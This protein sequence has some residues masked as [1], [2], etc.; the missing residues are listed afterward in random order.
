MRKGSFFLSLIQFILLSVLFIFMFMFYSIYL[1]VEEDVD[2]MQM[3]IERLEENIFTNNRYLPKSSVNEKEEIITDEFK[4]PR[5][6]INDAYPNLLAVDHFYKE[7]LPALL[8]SNFKPHGTLK[9]AVIGPPKNLHPFSN[10]ADVSDW[11]SSC[12]ASVSILEFGKFET[13]AE[14]MAIKMEARPQKNANVPEFWIHL[15]EGMFWQ[16]LTASLF[17]EKVK[18]SP[19]F[20]TRHP[21]TAQDF[22]FN[23]D[24]IMNP[25]VEES[26]AVALRTYF[27]GIEEIEIIDELTFIVRWKPH[28]IKEEKGITTYKIPYGA[29]LLTGNLRPLASFLY[30]YFSDGTKIVQDD[31]DPETYRKSSLWAQNFSQHWARNVIPSCGPWIFEGMTD[32]EISFRRNP[33]YFKPLAV[34]LENQVIEFKNDPNS[35]WQDFKSGNIDTYTLRPEQLLEWA[36]FQKSSEYQKQAN[37]KQAIESLEY[38]SR[39]YAYIG[40]NMAKPQFE[41]KKV[42]QA[43]TLAIDRRAIIANILNGMGVELSGPFFILSDAYDQSK[44]PWLYDP[45]QAKQL[46]EEEG[47]FDSDND[48]I[49]DKLVDGKR[50]R[51]EFVLTYFVKNITTKAICAFVATSLKRLGVDCKLNAVD[52]ADLSSL[53][54]DKAF[55]AICMGWSLGTPPEDPRQLWHSSGAHE[56]GSSNIVGFANKEADQIIDKLQFEDNIQKRHQLYHRLHGI[57]Y[58]E[59]PYTFLYIP[60]VMF[61]YRENLQNVFLPE[62]R[63]DLI[64]GANMLEPQPTIFWMR[65]TTSF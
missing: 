18:L 64:P 22:K 17:D 62:K 45:V 53:F 32:R 5:P 44:T 28:Q 59:C 25:H 58:D 1:K 4:K 37:N 16:P 26:G 48:G 41:S 20:L 7:K 50:I 2:G 60:K 6:H 42:R 65:E 55:D 49:L 38:I 36:E 8:G 13:L 34:L 33:D 3:G 29:K 27:D 23:F 61:L 40:W 47:W 19:H 30:Q 35:I 39:M 57:I 31:S 11:Y 52:I 24:V 9:G 15:R 43:M 63:Q 56:K 46:L 54:D 10:W 12:N 21:V 14:D 51:F